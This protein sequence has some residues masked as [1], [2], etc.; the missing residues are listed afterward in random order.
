MDKKYI[1]KSDLLDILESK[2]EC[3]DYAGNIVRKEDCDIVKNFPAADCVSRET[4]EQIA[5]E[6]DL[7]IS[8][9]NEIWKGLV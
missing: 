4:F 9:L 5:L 2:L 8:Q 3:N 6:R 1:C 7:A